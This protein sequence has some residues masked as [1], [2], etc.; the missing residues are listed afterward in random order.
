M[1]LSSKRT[2][3]RESLAGALSAMGLVHGTR[4]L[5]DNG[6]SRGESLHAPPMAPFR[7]DMANKI[8]TTSIAHFAFLFHSI[9]AVELDPK[10]LLAKREGGNF[11]G[12]CSC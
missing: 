10:S 3:K 1:V 9:P 7:Y 8:R 2:A 11:S 4:R 5:V 12:L 6:G